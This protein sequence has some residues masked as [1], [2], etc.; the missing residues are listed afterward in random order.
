VPWIADVVTRTTIT[1]VWG[2]AIRNRVTHQFANRAER[3]AAGVVPVAGMMCVT[4]DTGC[5]WIYTT[6]WV[7]FSTPWKSWSPVIFS[8]PSTGATQT[9]ATAA[10]Q[11]RYSS[12]TSVLVQCDASM[13]A[14][15]VMGVG[16][17][18]TNLPV[19]LGAAA[20]NN[21]M[22]AGAGYGINYR[23]GLTYASIV[24]VAT[25]GKASHGLASVG[26]NSELGWAEWGT[27]T[28]WQT[29]QWGVDFT[30]QYQVDAGPSDFL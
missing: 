1:S 20:G 26:P 15:A 14:Q 16:Q 12:P 10:A 17:M 7:P 4:L 5:V 23:T 30:V 29:N 19:P 3:D 22:V 2:N 8:N 27:S 9:V 25:D 21:V 24:R 13:T 11:Y 6:R 28:I 18:Q